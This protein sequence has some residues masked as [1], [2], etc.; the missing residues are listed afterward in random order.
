MRTW[1]IS[2]RSHVQS[3]LPLPAGQLWLSPWTCFSLHCS[4]LNFQ[5]EWGIKKEI[6]FPGKRNVESRYHLGFSLRNHFSF[7]FFSGPEL[8]AEEKAPRVWAGGVQREQSVRRGHCTFH[9]GLLYISCWFPVSD[10]QGGG[11][12][13]PS[14]SSLY[15]GEPNGA[16]LE[17]SGQPPPPLLLGFLKPRH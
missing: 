17:V 6:N 14:G 4:P 5:G 10:Q 3:P 13:N 1:K 15:V 8:M 7:F 9:W 2:G 11:R 16:S 12:F